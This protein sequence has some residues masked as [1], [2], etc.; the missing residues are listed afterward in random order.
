MTF[1]FF[2]KSFIIMA[3]PFFPTIPNTFSCLFLFPRHDQRRTS[4]VG[5]L[6]NSAAA[7]VR[8]GAARQ[9][10]QAF[11]HRPSRPAPR[12]AGWS[13]QRPPREEKH[14]WPHLPHLPWTRVVPGPET[15]ELRR[16][17]KKQL[18]PLGLASATSLIW[19]NK[20]RMPAHVWDVSTVQLTL[21]PLSSPPAQSTACTTRVFIRSVI[22]LRFACLW[23]GAACLQSLGGI[24]RNPPPPY[25]VVTLIDEGFFFFEELLHHR[26]ARWGH[27]QAEP[28]NKTGSCLPQN[29]LYCQ[30]LWQTEEL[31]G[32]EK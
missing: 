21:R 10:L 5:A 19:V 2:E 11:N 25:E 24:L 12:L 26:R 20:A 23:L 29:E 32:V 31:Q 1:W 18:Q 22:Y 13:S 14:P 28:G 17:R 7:P 8:T 9:F 3:V 6:I 27:Q 4:T 30:R 16:R 15:G